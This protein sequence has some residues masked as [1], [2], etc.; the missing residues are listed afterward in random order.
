VNE[1]QA[2][3]IDTG[4]GWFVRWAGAVADLGNPFH[5]EERQRDVWNEASAVGL[6]LMLWLGLAAAAAMTWFAG[7][8]ALPYAITLLA[9]LGVGSWASVLYAQALGVRLVGTREVL[10][11]RLIPY[12]VLLLVF[13]V[14]ALRAV[15]SGGFGAGFARGMAFGGGAA[16][17]WLAWSGLRARRR[18]RDG[19]V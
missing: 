18:L 6:Q 9:L 3:Q 13:V 4:D 14:G 1:Q 5:R 2:M 15:P 16:V 7:A 17:L 8:P 11:L 19:D 12:L 10:R